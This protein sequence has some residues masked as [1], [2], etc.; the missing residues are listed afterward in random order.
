VKSDILLRCDPRVVR[1]L[2]VPR[3]RGA[4][5][6]RAEA[7]PRQLISGPVSYLPVTVR[8][9]CAAPDAA[10]RLRSSNDG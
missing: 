6:N 7:Y 9:E 1:E 10:V 8:I 5:R 2:E 4:S 3:Q